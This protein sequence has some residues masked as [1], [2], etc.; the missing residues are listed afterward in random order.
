MTNL[1]SFSCFYSITVLSRCTT[2]NASFTV[3]NEEPVWESFSED[4][5]AP[6]VTK[7]PVF[8]SH[9]AAA[10]KAKKGAAQHGQGKIMNFFSKK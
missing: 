10:G 6:K 8:P 4:E 9:S 2:S 7:A 5:P 1:F 3:T